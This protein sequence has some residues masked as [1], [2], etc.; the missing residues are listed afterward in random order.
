MTTDEPHLA[1]QLRQLADTIATNPHRNPTQRQA[2]TILTAGIHLY[3]QGHTALT[4]SDQWSGPWPTGSGGPT[5]KGDHS[6]P[7]PNAALGRTD[8]NPERSY[9]QRLTLAAGAAVTASAAVTHLVRIIHQTTQRARPTDECT[10]RN[11]TDTAEPGR[12]GR[13]PSC[14][15]WR[16]RWLDNHPGTTR[17]DIPPVPTDTI[18]DRQIRR[19]RTHTT[20]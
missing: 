18:N 15:K 7:T 11:C 1:Y 9:H 12:Q 6:D 20:T 3:T 16:Q 19:R 10:E 5:S 14:A 17:A 4:K 13:C 8:L 2:E